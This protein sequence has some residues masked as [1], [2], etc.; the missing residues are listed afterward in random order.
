MTTRSRIHRRSPD[1]Y[2]LG[3]LTLIAGMATWV[4]PVLGEAPTELPAVQ[5][6]ATPIIEGNQ[7]DTFGGV[8]TVVGQEQVLELNAQDLPAA[9]RRTPGVTISRYNPI[10]AFGGGEGG[11]VFVRGMGSS[12]PGGEVK[13][14]IDGVPVSMGVFNHPLMDI[15]P[16]DAAASIQVVKGPQPGRFGNTFSAIDLAPKRMTEEGQTARLQAQ[17]GSFNTWIE[18]LDAG[19]KQGPFDAWI[20]QGWRRSSG[21]RELS[22]GR[23]GDVYGRIGYA[24]SPHW[25]A[26]VTGLYTDAK[27][28]DPGQIGLP[29]TRQGTYTTTS[30]LGVLTLAHDY[31]TVKGHLKL[32]WNDG[33]GYWY[34]QP[35]ATRDTLTNWQQYGLRWMETVRPWAGGEVL[36]GLDVERVSGYTRF[37]SPK[38]QTSRWNGPTFGL[39]SPYLVLSHRF[40]LGQEWRLTPSAGVRYYSHNQFQSEWA[41]QAGLV[42]ANANTELHASYSR[43]VNY[44]GLNVV[45]FSQSVIPA[46]GNSWENLVPETLNH[47]EFGVSQR[48]TPRLRMDVTLFSDQGNN[49]YVIVQPPPPPPRFTNIESFRIDGAEL[50][51]TADPLD[52]LSLFSGLTLLA[53]TPSDLPYAPGAAASLGLNWRPLQRLQINLDAEYQTAMYALSQ[54]RTWGVTNTERV[55]DFFTLNGRIAFKLTDAPSKVR[56]ELF[57]ALENIT[58]T[59]YQYRPGYPMPGISAM[60]GVNLAL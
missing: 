59:S 10:G 57:L 2:V 54:A 42:L 58:N 50:T 11:A 7:V 19:I 29:A 48:F 24:I 23:T 13:T 38:E 39:D 16:V 35:G 49:R 37:L 22:G 56:S 15:L 45:I 30:G 21:D 55:S 25:S 12:R 26:S 33:Q 47:F 46:L 3:S 41:P 9:L 31:D 36:F 60:V 14:Y 8:S 51:V 52:N 17:G 28:Q 43:G 1:G 27:A 18:K 20:S 34:D 6:L 53:T 32:Y 4:G 40:A 44:P 5:V